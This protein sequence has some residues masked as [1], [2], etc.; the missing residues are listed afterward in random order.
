[1][2]K[3][4]VANVQRKHAA[5]VNRRGVQARE[6]SEGERLWQMD[7]DSSLSGYLYLDPSNPVPLL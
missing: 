6:D 3:D 4:G 7:P 5:N 2:K 1:M